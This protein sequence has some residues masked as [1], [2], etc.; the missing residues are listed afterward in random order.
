MFSVKQRHPVPMTLDWPFIMRGRAGV[1]PYHVLPSLQ[2]H[3]SLG[4]VHELESVEEAEKCVCAHTLTYTH[5]HITAAA[6]ELTA[7]VYKCQHHKH[8]LAF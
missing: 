5:R 7:V 4:G 1:F 6:V 2:L 3:G 8:H